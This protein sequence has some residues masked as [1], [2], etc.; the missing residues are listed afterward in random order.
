MGV[1]EGCHMSK[2]HWNAVLLEPDVRRSHLFELIEDSYNLIV[3][4]LTKK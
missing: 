1:L 2:K 3:S 4:K